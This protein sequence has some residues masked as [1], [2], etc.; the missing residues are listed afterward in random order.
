MAHSN[1]IRT[2]ARRAAILC[3]VGNSLNV[4]VFGTAPVSRSPLRPALCP[5]FLAR[6]FA[7]NSGG[8]GKCKSITRGQPIPG[9]QSG[10][11]SPNRADASHAWRGIAL[12]HPT[13]GSRA[14][15]WCPTDLSAPTEPPRPRSVPELFWPDPRI[16]CVSPQIEAAPGVGAGYCYE[17]RR[18]GMEL[19]TYRGGRLAS[20]MDPLASLCPIGH[21]FCGPFS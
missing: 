2:C 8:K 15:P 11:P 13:R 5:C 4:C 10:T 12:A 21:T 7:R 16:C 3:W 1:S 6:L 17:I 14:P 9:S 18:L 19:R 20:G